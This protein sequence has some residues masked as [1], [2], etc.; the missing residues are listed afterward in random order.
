M[1][2]ASGAA[3]MAP[4]HDGLALTNRRGDP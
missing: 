3:Q 1:S 4:D 2:V